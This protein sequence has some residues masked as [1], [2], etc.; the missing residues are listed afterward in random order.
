[1]L[2]E[3]FT[4]VVGRNDRWTG[5]AASEPYECGW[6][7]E[8]I[9]FVRALKQPKGPQPVVRVEISP[10][11][12]RWIAEGTEAPMPADKDGIVALRVTH[13]GNWLRL[14]A[15]FPPGAEST[16]LVTVHTKA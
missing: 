16:V 6:A 13:F 11:G 1:M 15:D 9:L 4:A 14:A 10:D 8:A 7:R 5:M 3:N 12:M 2:P